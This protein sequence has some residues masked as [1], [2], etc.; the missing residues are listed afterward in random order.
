MFRPL[1]IAYVDLKRYIAD[2]PSLAFGI[3]LPIV[4]FALMYGAFGGEETFNATAHIANL[5]RGAMSQ[6]LLEGLEQVNGLD[7]KLYTEREINEALDDSSVVYAAIIPN[8]FT[9][10]LEAG[11]ATAITFRRRGSGGDE[12]QIVAGIIRSV[13]QDIASESYVRSVVN[14][15]VKDVDVPRSAVDSAIDDAKLI[16]AE[17]PPIAVRTE[18]IGGDE[19]DFAVKRVMPG[20]LV[21]IL[22]LAVMLSAQALVEERRNGTL[23]RLLTTQLTSN[24]L[25]LGKFFAGITR[26]M[27]QA[28]VL[29]T[30]AFI[31]LRPG[32]VDAFLL[33]LAVSLLLAAAVS[34]IGLVISAVARTRDQASWA[35][36]SLTMF[37]TVFGGTFFELVP[38]S[39]FELLSRFT[40]NR[41]AIDAIGAAVDGSETLA[42]QGTELAVMG[43]VA[44]VCLLAAR[45]LF[46]S[47]GGGR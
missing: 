6:A 26:T 12:G 45:L 4:L 14:D 41:Y 13:V 43:G 15:A 7:V 20:I 18:V 10:N 35:A 31:A 5:D 30:L 38:G 8:D 19:D 39:A 25:F 44:V 17:A 40:L 47:A 16:A 11:R 27:F 21:M 42:T 3:L 9:E 28:V 33:T 29:L 2:R 32:G 22:L 37:M 1:D 36:V 24:Q 23:E 34:A 46:R